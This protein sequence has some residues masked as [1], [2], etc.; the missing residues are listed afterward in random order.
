MDLRRITDQ[1]H[2]IMMLL[3]T[4][5]MTGCAGSLVALPLA[6]PKDVPVSILRESTTYA[7]S[8]PAKLQPLLAIVRFPARIEDSA[9]PVMARAYKEQYLNVPKGPTWNES[10][11]KTPFD[12]EYA[13]QQMLV[14]STYFAAEMYEQLKKRLPPNSVALQ[15]M[16][17]DLDGQG[18]LTL[19]SPT[20]LS[21]SV[22]YVDFFA[23]YSPKRAY[24]A[25]PET[26]GKYLSP[27][28]SV[29][30]SIEGSRD[31]FGAVAGMKQIP[32]RAER[33]SQAGA[34]GRGFR[35]NLVTFLNDWLADQCSNNSNNPQEKSETETDFPSC[36][37]NQNSPINA[38]GFNKEKITRERPFKHGQYFELPLVEYAMSVEE[39][40]DQSK[41]PEG[42]LSNPPSRKILGVYADVI[43]EALNV[44]D[45]EKAVKTDRRQYAAIYDPEIA[46]V[47]DTELLTTERGSRLALIRKFE[48]TEKEFLTRSDQKFIDT[49]Y[50]GTFGDAI[51][52]T[53]VSEEEVHS[54]L[55]QSQTMDFLAGM[56]ELGIQVGGAPLGSSGAM[57]SQLVNK[58]TQ[59]MVERSNVLKEVGSAFDKHFKR[60]NDE[61]FEFT[62]D[63]VG[64]KAVNIQ[65]TGLA[66]LRAKMRALY[67]EKVLPLG[68]DDDAPKHPP[69]TPQNSEGTRLSARPTSKQV[70]KVNIATIQRYLAELGYN[71]GPADGV[72][73]PRTV[74]AIRVFQKQVGLPVDGKPSD[75]LLL[76][77]RDSVESK[78]AVSGR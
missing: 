52:K 25:L 69:V 72:V 38:S 74:Q 4:F 70:A 21:P 78:L 31:T 64:G 77:L 61:I 40:A 75:A 30:T 28:V 34:N 54:K 29:H 27:V 24:I 36:A 59:M 6:P 46:A 1:L 45:H 43:I 55:V 26:F 16:S 22:L 20:K 56:L 8:K 5:A 57:A 73:G 58:I 60:V 23:Y 76:V 37:T 44:I 48:A 42:N 10:D 33:N 49:T 39:L 68:S 13:H 3:L 65:S 9:E 67:R 14:R 17:I 12:N 50:K 62:V 63:Q 15:P 19:R 71:T 32:L 2:Y 41:G 18:Y 47:N 7:P 35:G 53:M 66:D 51:R 11:E